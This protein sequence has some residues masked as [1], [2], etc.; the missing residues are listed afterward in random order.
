MTCLFW[1][2]PVCRH[3]TTN[4]FFGSFWHANSKFS[5]TRFAIFARFF[6]PFVYGITGC[7]GLFSGLFINFMY[8]SSNSAEK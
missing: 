8:K 4:A 3:L 7:E 6:C 2:L 1:H 5:I